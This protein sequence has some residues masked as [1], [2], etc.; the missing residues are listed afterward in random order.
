MSSK[1]KGI[2]E[3]QKGKGHEG[4]CAQ[5]RISPYLKENEYSM[6]V[7]SKIDKTTTRCKSKLQLEKL[8]R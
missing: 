8:T 2:P 3:G 4:H 6:L 7:V 1:W 5:T